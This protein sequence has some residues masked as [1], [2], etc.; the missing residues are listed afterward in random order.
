MELYEFMPSD[1]IKEMTMPIIERGFSFEYFTEKG[2]DKSCSY[3]CRYKKGRDYLDW[4]EVSEGS[5]ISIVVY[6]NG[7]Y[8]FPTLKLLYP[9]EHR[10]FFWKHL[11][12]KPLMSDKREL[13][14][15]CLV[16]EITTKP[17]FF[18]IKL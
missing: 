17:D 10:A 11:F 8:T 3:I 15:K 13:I 9:K 18:G 1:K 7:R 2:G 4:R 5:E 16:A 12:K 14:A 6:V